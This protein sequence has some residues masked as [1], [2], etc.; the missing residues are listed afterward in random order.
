MGSLTPAQAWAPYAQAA[1]NALNMNAADILAQWLYETGN[2][3]NLGSTKYNNLAGIKY[4][5]NSVSGAF[6][7]SDSQHAGYANLD[8]FVSDYIRVMKSSNYDQVRKSTSASS[9]LSAI[10][11]SP[12][13]VADYNASGFMG[14]YKQATAALGQVPVSSIG[15]GLDSLPGSDILNGINGD[16]ILSFL[17][18]KWW[19]VAGAL[20]IIAVIRR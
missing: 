17:K 11:A 8:A 15:I 9:F 2:G 10:N 13:S 20:V 7:P 6:Q 16:G 18:E 14:Y 3:T 19:M 12:W 4:T 1:G 5:K